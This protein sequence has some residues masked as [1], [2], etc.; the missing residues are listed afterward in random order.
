MTRVKEFG[1]GVEHANAKGFIRCARLAEDLGYKTFWVPEDPYFRGGF[2][3]ASAIAASTES[4]RIG[5]GIVNPYTRHPALTA[6]E[7][8]ALEEVSD[9]RSILALGASFKSYIEG[10]LNIPY[11]KPG[12]A[13]REMIEITRR[14]FRGEQLNY[15]GKLFN[16]RGAKFNFQPPRTEIPIHLGVLGPKN[17]ELAGE[18]GDGVLLSVMTSPGYAKYA[19]EHVKAGAERAGRSLDNFDVSAYL[20]ISIGEDDRAARDA[21][22]PLLAMMISILPLNGIVDHPMLSCAGITPNLAQSFAESFIRGELPVA[23]VE[24]W[25]IDQFAIA[26]TPDRCRDAMAKIVDAGVTHPV[27]FEIHGLN[28]E[29]IIRD[30][31]THLMPHFL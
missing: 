24:D 25:I 26:G 22:K 15:D 4:I 31:H 8:G 13:L 16:I 28:P 1:A 19:V 18:M 17:L 20:L 10:Q 2:S 14:L 3:L 29:Q 30:V 12:T 6:M 5:I 21:V 7:L 27:A 23:L 11:V 9:G